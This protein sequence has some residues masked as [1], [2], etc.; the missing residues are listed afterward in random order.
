MRRSRR[1][2]A[3]AAAGGT[4]RAALG[5]VGRPQVD[6]ALTGGMTAAERK[7]TLAGLKAVADEGPPR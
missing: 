1:R 3:P 5:V 2:T 6:K 7:G 4:A